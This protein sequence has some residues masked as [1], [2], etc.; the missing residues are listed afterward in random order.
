MS[1]KEAEIQAFPDEIREATGGAIQPSD[2][3]QWLHGGYFNTN[4]PKSTPG[5]ARA[6][7]LSAVYEAVLLRAWSDLGLTL[8]EAKAGNKV[9][10]DA[11]WGKK[12]AVIEKRGGQHGGGTSVP[13]IA[14]WAED[15]ELPVVLTQGKEREEFGRMFY[16]HGKH[17][18]VAKI[19]AIHL[20]A[21]LSPVRRVWG[22]D[23]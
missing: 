16:G 14:V 15:A 22:L 1:K 6:L 12:L 20:P 21:L 19:R 17:G 23:D 13:Y 7:P 11:L 10:L 3:R 18:P 8:A 5:R 9:I 4:L 2:I